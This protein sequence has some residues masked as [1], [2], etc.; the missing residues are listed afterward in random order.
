IVSYTA[1]STFFSIDVRMNGWSDASP[2]V[3]YW[4]ESTPIAH[5]WVLLAS[6]YSFAAAN[7]PPP[8]PP[9]AWNTTSEPAPNCAAAISFAF[10][11]S[12]KPVKS[13]GWEMYFT[14]T[15]MSGLIFFAPATYPASNFLMRSVSTPP[16]KPIFPVLDLSAAAAPTRYEPS[17]SANVS[18]ATFGWSTTESTIANCASG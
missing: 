5:T 1:T 8:E 17:F 4:S 12:L 9:A 2:A 13:G 14:S 7:R 10:A 11:G 16:M 18:D 3:L 15:W 6:E